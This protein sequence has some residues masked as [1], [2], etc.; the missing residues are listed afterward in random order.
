MA[1]RK[2]YLLLLAALF[3]F[4]S[5]RVETGYAQ[6]STPTQ[7]PPKVRRTPTLTP[8]STATLTPAVPTATRTPTPGATVTTTRPPTRTQPVGPTS[9]RTPTATQTRTSVA[10]ASPSSTPSRTPTRPLTATPAAT[11][12]APGGAIIVDHNSVALFDQIPVEY[13]TAARN[14]SLLF[15]DRSV[16]AN[17][18]DGL[19]CLASS[20]ATAPNHC[21]RF[22]HPVPQFSV[23]SSEVF[24][25]GQYPRP[26][27][28]YGSWPSSTIPVELNCGVP[29]DF[30]YQKLDCFIRYVDANPN[31]Y[32]VFSYQ[33]SYLEVSSGSDIASGTTGYFVPQANRM[34]IS[35]FEAL[36]SRHPS[37][38]FIHWTSSL[39]RNTGS[40]ESTAFNHQMR[41]YALANDKILFDVA[42]IEAHDP[43]GNPCYDNRDS[44]PYLNENYP[45]DG[46]A[47]P[48]ICQHY[49]SEVD[50]GHLGS[51]SG[52]K[53]RIAKAFWVLMAQV[54]GWTP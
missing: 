28:D 32:R 6:Q 54:A 44:V 26:N 38:V 31:A 42:D 16:G 27:W 52:A 23:P 8:T 3:A 10:T 29:A 25:S 2:M 40:S 41:Q 24:W 47:Y 22:E 15:V 13:L 17:I 20:H 50:G 37:R 19:T 53:I 36:E 12:P 21:K 34:D 9:T 1:L 30:W 51:V 46:H 35:D 11:L 18:S 49:T 4:G 14:L 33:N 43:A 39:A 48:A 45:N 5:G 7:R